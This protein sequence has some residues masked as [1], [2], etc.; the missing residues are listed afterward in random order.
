MRF[1]KAVGFKQARERF[2]QKPIVYV[3]ETAAGTPYVGRTND[4]ARR[5]AEHGD[6]RCHRVRAVVIKSTCERART[7]KREAVR[8]ASRSSNRV[9][10]GVPAYCTV[11]LRKS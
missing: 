5:L 6:K 9:T 11:P 2:R 3:C 7:E 8:L 10:P 1:S 4:G